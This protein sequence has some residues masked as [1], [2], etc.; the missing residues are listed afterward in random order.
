MSSPACR[1]SF[2]MKNFKANGDAS[3]GLR[4]TMKLR[5][6]NKY[7]K[8]NIFEAPIENSSIF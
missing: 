2:M 6:F 5:E 3:R 7:A 8:V 1:E 4:L